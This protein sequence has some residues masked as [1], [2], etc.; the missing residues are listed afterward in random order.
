MSRISRTSRASRTFRIA[1][2]V[3]AMLRVSQVFRTCRTYRTFRTRRILT[4][5]EVV[6]FSLRPQTLLRLLLLRY[7]MQARIRRRHFL[8]H[9]LVLLPQLLKLQAEKISRSIAAARHRSIAA[10]RHRSI[11]AAHRRAEGTSRLTVGRQ[12]RIL[13]EAA[14]SKALTDPSSWRKKAIAD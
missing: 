5:P 2:T 9:R 4:C 14:R 13:A 6:T 7:R 1:R 12:R 8:T 10:A 11:A 3:R